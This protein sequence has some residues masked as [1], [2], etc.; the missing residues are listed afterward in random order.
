VWVERFIQG[1]SERERKKGNEKLFSE[2]RDE[3]TREAR[4]LKRA[5]ALT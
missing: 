1:K 3:R 4:K 5:R 2:C